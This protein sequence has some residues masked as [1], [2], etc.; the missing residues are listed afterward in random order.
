MSDIDSLEWLDSHADDGKGVM[1]LM[2]KKGILRTIFG[3]KMVIND[4]N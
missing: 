2:F 4:H 3:R 1:L